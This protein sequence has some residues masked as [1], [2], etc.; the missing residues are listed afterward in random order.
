MNV[1]GFLLTSC[2]FPLEIDLVVGDEDGS[3]FPKK[4]AY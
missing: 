1:R 2:D 3:F 4:D